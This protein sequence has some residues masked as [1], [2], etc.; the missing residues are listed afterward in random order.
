L[1]RDLQLDHVRLGS[2]HARLVGR[3]LD[4]GHV[5]LGDG[6]DGPWQAPSPAVA[7]GLNVLA[8]SLDDALVARLHLVEAG[9][10][11]DGDADDE[12][13]QQHRGRAAAATAAK[14]RFDAFLPVL[15]GLVEIATAGGRFLAP[16]VVVRITGLIPGHVSCFA[17]RA[18]IVGRHLRPYKLRHE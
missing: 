18:T 2:E 8:E 13:D 1:H 5:D 10:H 16:G 17:R 15:Q 4:P 7:D 6:F 12:A 9:H 14:Q 11:P 3:G